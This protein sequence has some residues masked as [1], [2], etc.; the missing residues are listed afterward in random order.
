MEA[1][2]LG[3]PNR[4]PDSIVAAAR[5]GAWEA[6]TG[7]PLAAYLVGRA[8]VGREWYAAAAPHLETAI[9]GG[10]RT[11]PRIAR[12]A[13]RLRAV[14]ACAEGDGDAR[15][16]MRRLVVASDGPYAESGG[17]RLSTLRFLDRCSISSTAP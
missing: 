4:P 2:L 1:L 10:A 8:L 3:E 13:I 12:E 9:A 14:V 16:R 15:D 7:S 11:T 17:R 6:H 5:T